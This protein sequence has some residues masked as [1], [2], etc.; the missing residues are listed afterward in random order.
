[1]IVA[2]HVKFQVNFKLILLR[3]TYGV[4]IGFSAVSRVWRVWNDLVSCR[5]SHMLD[6][7]V[8]VVSERGYTILTHFWRMSGSFRSLRGSG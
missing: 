5:M 7:V 2:G 6:D 3:I 4:K 1:M 8:E